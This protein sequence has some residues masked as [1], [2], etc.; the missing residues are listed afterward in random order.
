MAR[1]EH[2]PI[3][4]KAM[5]RVEKRY[6][7]GLVRLGFTVHV[8]REEEERLSGRWQDTSL[9]LWRVGSRGLTPPLP[10]VSTQEPKGFFVDRLAGSHSHKFYGHWGGPVDNPNPPNPDTPQTKEFISEGLPMVRIDE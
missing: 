9:R 5:D 6:L 4:K 3:Y 10:G 1:Y 8:V 7:D 2:L